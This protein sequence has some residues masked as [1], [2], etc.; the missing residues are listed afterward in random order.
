MLT[1]HI[2]NYPLNPVSYIE[3]WY[4]LEIQDRVVRH[5]RDEAERSRC[6]V[7]AERRR[8]ERT[9]GDSVLDQ[10]GRGERGGGGGG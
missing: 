5:Q 10:H 4:Y 6:P 1:T 2:P 3:A 8:G 9:A 7:Q